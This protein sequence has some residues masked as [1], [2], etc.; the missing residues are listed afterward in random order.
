M[1]ETLLVFICEF[2]R[3]LDSEN[4]LGSGLIDVIQHR[5]QRGRLAG[6]RRPGDQ[7]QPFRFAAH[8]LHDR[9]HAQLLH[10]WDRVAKGP[11]AGGIGATLPIHIHSETSNILE[12]VG[13]VQFPGL[14][15]LFAL[16]VVE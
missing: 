5:R 9:R 8:L 2:D 15:K 4:M 13:A 14:L 7:H 1:N 16:C 6:A 3:I 11:Q 10:R 12:A